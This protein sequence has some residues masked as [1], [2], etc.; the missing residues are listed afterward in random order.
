ME[1]D[2]I[3]SL[4]SFLNEN[5]DENYQ[6]YII[7]IEDLITRYKDLED[8]WKIT[9]DVNNDLLITLKDCVHKDKVKEKMKEVEFY[10]ENVDNAEGNAMYKVLQ[11]LLEES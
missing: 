10:I 11:E 3:E 6:D 5:G 7:A 4:I 9:K 1:E 8:K 2:I